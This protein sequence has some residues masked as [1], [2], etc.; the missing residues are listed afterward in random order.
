MNKSIARLFIGGCFFV[1]GLVFWIR[2]ELPY[3][4]LFF[5]AGMLYLIGKGKKFTA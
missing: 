5:A 2:Q 3:S 1:G 4:I